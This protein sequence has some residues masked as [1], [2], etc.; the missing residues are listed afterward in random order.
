MSAWNNFFN[1][2]F[3]SIGLVYGVGNDY[4]IFENNVDNEIIIDFS[5]A[6][7]VDITLIITEI[8]IQIGPGWTS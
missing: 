3:E 1:D 8:N 6:I 7:T 5:N 4:E 2:S